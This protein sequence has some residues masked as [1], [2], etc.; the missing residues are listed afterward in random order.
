MMYPFTLVHERFGG[1][2]RT[3]STCQPD[4]RGGAAHPARLLDRHA[5][6]ATPRR[7]AAV[8]HSCPT[9][10]SRAASSCWASRLVLL[11]VAQ[12]VFAR[13]E[14]E[15]PGAPLMTTID[16]RWTT[17]P[18][19]SRCQSHRSLK[20]TVAG[21]GPRPARPRD[22]SF[23][24][25]D[26]VSSRSHA[27]RVD[28]ADGPQRLRQ[29]DAAQARQRRHAPRRRAQVLT[30][31]RIAGLIATGAGF[32]N[33]LSGRENLYINAAML[34][35]TQGR[36]RRASSTRSSS[37]ADVGQFLDTAGRQLLLGHVRPPR[38]LR[39]GPRRLPTSSSPTRCWRWGTGRSSASAKRR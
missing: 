36:D 14:T 32:H 3:R 37:F 30:R 19:P 4:R 16:R 25:L 10:C 5:R 17:S 18:R 15:R 8:R 26:D 29:V 21:Q 39:R 24:A 1:A 34:G 11:A 22:E 20:Q 31:G 9:T 35:M 28:R 2:D 23:N 12:C 38:L 6:R 13:L 27:G 33:E 7:T